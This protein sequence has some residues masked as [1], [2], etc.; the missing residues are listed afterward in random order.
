MK[1][2]IPLLVLLFI[3]GCSIEGNS[4]RSDSAI[5]R[6]LF[7]LVS[8]SQVI[9]A[10]VAL[11][12]GETIASSSSIVNSR[13]ITPGDVSAGSDAIM[14]KYFGSNWN[15][16]DG[17]GAWLTWSPKE[18]Y[19]N[20]VVQPEI[21]SGV[22][23]IPSSGIITGLYGD[24]SID[25]Y[26]ELSEIT[27]GEKYSIKLYIYPRSDFNID[28]I[29][30]EYIVY[31]SSISGEWS[32]SPFDNRDMINKLSKDTTYYR[33]GSF[34]D[35]E[36][37]WSS[38]MVGG[39]RR[40]DEVKSSAPPLTL[41]VNNIIG[42]YNNYLYYSSVPNFTYSTVSNF[43]SSETI[44]NVKGKRTSKDILEYYTEE[45]QKSW[46]LQY[47]ESDKSWDTSKE[48][49]RSYIDRSTGDSNY[50]SLKISGGR[51]AETSEINRI[52]KT[53]TTYRSELHTWFSGIESVSTISNANSIILDLT[54][55]G[56][57]YEG[58]STN[59]W[60]S[61]GEVYSYSINTTTGEITTSWLSSSSRTLSNETINITDL[62][63]IYISVGNWSF[64][65][66]YQLGEFFGTY[67]YKGD[68]EEVTFDHLGIDLGSGKEKW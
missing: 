64:T 65:G 42:N 32:W 57:I 21:V 51:W 17:G 52:V 12:D 28:Y 7:Q 35:R 16:K 19:N 63:D 45:G 54:K 67:S 27:S 18:V 20:P 29:L 53:S 24:S 56:S 40:I 66:E 9:E 13:T 33:D 10:G 31:E 59:Y 55:N 4:S 37:I 43:Y 34:K 3:S 50:I 41:G 49:T 30:E 61:S 1:I 26:L 11:A 14:D 2:Y 23:R 62:S 58:K 15:S 25:F 36:T 68:K 47:I 5:K 46:N 8:L 38:T 39:N 6:D 60:G 48:V 44:G 22:L